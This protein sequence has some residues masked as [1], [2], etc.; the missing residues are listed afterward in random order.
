MEY[1]SKSQVLLALFAVAAFGP[2]VRGQISQATM[3]GSIKDN[4]GAVVPNAAVSLKNKA[5]ARY[6][7]S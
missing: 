2:G 6:D 4:T 5:P 1:F 7:P 3:E